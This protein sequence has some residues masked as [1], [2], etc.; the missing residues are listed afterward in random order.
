LKVIDP[1]TCNGK[2]NGLWL[3]FAQFYEDHHDLTN[4]R[5]VFKKASEVDFKSAEDLA[6][7]WCSWS[8]MELRQGF[9]DRALNIMRE[10]VSEPAYS[11]QRR[12]AKAISQGKGNTSTNDDHFEGITSR[13]RLHRSVS[14]WGFYLDLEES[15]G[16]IQSCRAAYDRAID[17]KV[18]TPQMALNYASFLE[19]KNYF[20]DSFRVYENAILLFTF[21]HVKAIWLAYLDRFIARYEGTKIER[22]RDLFEQAIAKVPSENAAEFYLK[23]A[24]TEESYGLMRH[25]MAIYDKATRAVPENSRLD[26]YRLYIKKVEQ[27]YG[28]TKTRAI[29][30]RAIPELQDEMSRMLCVEFADMERKLGCI[31]IVI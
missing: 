8:E 24:K 3:A 28:L 13:D 31:I 18:I 25:A 22:L 15:F 26:M 9:P 16:T 10:A 12:K 14:V 17:I 19:E 29:Y 1:K 20:E 23:Y 27:L 5:I 2:V 7:V 30:E 21:P 4:A 6:A 11:L